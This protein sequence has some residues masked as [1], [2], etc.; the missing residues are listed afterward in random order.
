MSENEP[1]SREPEP[2]KS[3]APPTYMPR[4]PLPAELDEVSEAQALIT[5]EWAAGDEDPA[6]PGG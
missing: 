3:D 4:P 1:T 2:E 5:D 6:N